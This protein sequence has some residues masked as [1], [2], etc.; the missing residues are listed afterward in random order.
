MRNTTNWSGLV[1]V[2]SENEKLSP[3]PNL[4]NQSEIVTTAVHSYQLN[5]KQFQIDLTN[6][7]I[8]KCAETYFDYYVKGSSEN[9]FPLFLANNKKD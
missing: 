6:N 5:E 2:P 4:D 3:I 7:N 9:T 1:K 8:T